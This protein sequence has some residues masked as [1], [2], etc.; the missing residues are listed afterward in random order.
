MS[1]DACCPSCKGAY[2]IC[3]D[4]TCLHHIENGIIEDRKDS[5]RGSIRRP[6]EDQAIR[7]I[8]RERRRGRRT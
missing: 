2:G 5:G 6:T 7:N 4:K 8:M 1:Y 3:R